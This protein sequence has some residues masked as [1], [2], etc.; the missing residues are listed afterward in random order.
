LLG[1]NVG[2]G[3][4]NPQQKLH[5][6]GNVQIAGDIDFTGNL[7][8]NGVLY[9]ETSVFDDTQ[10]VRH[11]FG[12]LQVTTMGNYFVGVRISW[13]TSTDSDSAKM[14]LSGKC[15]IAGDDDENAYRRF[16]T[17]VH[18]KNDSLAQKPRA[19]VNTE[20]A[21]FYTDDFSGLT[22]QILRATDS[23]IDV[24]IKWTSTMAPYVTNTL[25]ETISPLSLGSISYSNIY[26]S[27]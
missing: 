26:G 12:G 23:S 22:H 15:S 14:H 18:C 13:S 27:W 11:A 4:T 8:K 16:E 9:G 1:S 24:K 21:N 3:T 7:Y 25:F 6:D 2:I 5:V 19:I 17:I 10:V 20:S